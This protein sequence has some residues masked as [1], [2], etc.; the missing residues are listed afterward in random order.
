MK[1]VLLLPGRFRNAIRTED[2]NTCY[3]SCLDSCSV[4]TDFNQKYSE[5]GLTNSSDML[6][7]IRNMNYKAELVRAGKEMLNRHLTVETWGNLSL[8]DPEKGYVYLTPSA[9]PYDTI[10]E[11]D[12]VVCDLDGN[13]L[14]G[15]RK[16][17]VEKDLHLL[18]YRNRPDINAIIH[19]HPEDSLV[20]G[21]L[22]QDIPAVI[23]EGAQS[24]GGTVHC[25]EYALPGTEQLAIN[26]LK[27]LGKDGM[28]CLLAN[29]GA[30]CLGKDMKEAF[31]TGTVLEMEARIYLK[32]LSVGKPVVLSDENV[33]YMRDF[34]LHHYGQGK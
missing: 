31:K 27:A 21:V 17:T 14:E 20:F 22:H 28:A 12:V 18:V 7:L 9:M 13:I 19:T 10:T 30:I 23:D 3:P 1:P 2:R 24:L 33:A 16:P 5:S 8:R 34:M 11:E 26:T 15:S 6:N 32:A 25:A 29:H 4:E